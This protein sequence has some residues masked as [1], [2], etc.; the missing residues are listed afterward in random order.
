MTDDRKGEKPASAALYDL[1]E[2]H[3][4]QLARVEQ[5][6][7]GNDSVQETQAELWI[8]ALIDDPG[9]STFVAQGSAQLFASL[10]IFLAARQKTSASGMTDEPIENGIEASATF[11]GVLPA[12][13]RKLLLP[14]SVSFKRQ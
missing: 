14:A 7:L 8:E 2:R 4:P 6:M 10:V 1:L 12:D 13:I 3:L 11:A 5:V 9:A